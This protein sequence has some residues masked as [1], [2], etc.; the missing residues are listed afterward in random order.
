M[1]KTIIL[2]GFLTI[3]VAFNSYAHDSD[4]IDQLENETQEISLRL[5]KVESMLIGSSYAN[6]PATSGVGWPSVSDW[7]KLTTDMSTSD[8]RKILGE[9]QRVE[10]GTRASW[11][12]PNGGS[13]MFDEGKVYR[14]SEPYQ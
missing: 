10:G 9:P 6:E 3:A 7:R 13:I 4:R 12:Y 14:W 8:V 2:I 1:V 11:Y 5:S